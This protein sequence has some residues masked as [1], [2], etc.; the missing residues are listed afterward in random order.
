MRPWLSALCF[1]P[2]AIY[3]KRL[4]N[5]SRVN[6]VGALGPESQAWWGVTAGVLVLGAAL[7]VW[8]CFHDDGIHWPDEIYQTLEPAHRLVFGFGLRAW[9]FVEGGRSWAFPGLLAGFLKLCSG[10]GLGEPRSYILAVRLLMTLLGLLS[11]LG[12]YQLARVSGATRR[13]SAMAC[14][15]WALMA[16]AIF[17][18]PRAMN[19]TASAVPIVFGLA[20][21][22]DPKATRGRLALGSS[23]LGF[24]V[25]LRLQNTFVCA[26]VLIVLAGRRAWRPLME[27]AGV[28]AIWALLYG[29]LDRLTWGGWFHSLF[30][31]WRYNVGEGMM[32]FYQSSDEWFFLRVLLGVM[33]LVTLCLLAFSALALR[34]VPGLIFIVAVFIGA[35]S[36]VPHKEL[37][38]I[39]PV[40]PMWGAIAAVGLDVPKGR[41]ARWVS[42]GVA[43]V[44]VAWSALNHRALTL[45]E[46]GHPEVAHAE[47]ASA[48]DVNGAAN[49]LLLRAHEEPDLCGLKLEH[50]Q[51]IWTGGYSYLH[52]NVPFYSQ[53]GPPPESRF[54]NY[55]LLPRNAVS[56]GEV[57]ASDGKFALVRLFSGPCTHD[58]NFDDRSLY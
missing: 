27:A 12:S 1:S 3:K 37:R 34:R 50:L 46:V 32:A 16:P 17:F 45:E 15:L 47:L 23:L 53:S 54:Y 9:E 35:H 56:F 29:L 49:R 40:L 51:K 8:L 30:A 52:R 19:E 24:S 5:P 38:F 25:L 7:R 33:P 42:W 39:M 18:A 2:W 36:F 14:A 55:L 21:A 58:P 6:K 13:S 28:L 57:R 44:A 48:Y 31:Y 4:D 11:A 43:A 22:L 26:A 10:L 20:L 41:V